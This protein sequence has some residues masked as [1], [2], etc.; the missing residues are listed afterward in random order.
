MDEDINHR[1]DCNHTLPPLPPDR[2]A[3]SINGPSESVFRQAYQEALEEESLERCVIQIVASTT[4]GN[5]EVGVL[6]SEQDPPPPIPQ[7]PACEICFERAEGRCQGG[8]DSCGI[9]LCGGCSDHHLALYPSHTPVEFNRTPV[10][11]AAYQEVQKMIEIV[12]ACPDPGCV[13][14]D[15]CCACMEEAAKQTG[16]S[17]S[18]IPRWTLRCDNCQQFMKEAQVRACVRCQLSPL[19]QEC[20]A[21]HQVKH[22]CKETQPAVVPGIPESEGGQMLI[23][24]LLDLLE[25]RDGNR[26]HSMAE[27]EL[28]AQQY[29]CSQRDFGE[30]PASGADQAEVI[31]EEPASGADRAEAAPEDAPKRHALRCKNCGEYMAMV[32]AYPCTR[33]WG[34][35]Y[36]LEC[37]EPHLDKCYCPQRSFEVCGMKFGP[38]IAPRNI[39]EVPLELVQDVLRQ[40]YHQ[41]EVRTRHFMKKPSIGSS[42]QLRSAIHKPEKD[43]L[44]A[45]AEASTSSCTDQQDCPKENEVLEELRKH[46]AQELFTANLNIVRACTTALKGNV[47]APILEC[48][49]CRSEVEDYQ[50]CKFLGCLAILCSKGCVNRHAE[51]CTKFQPPQPH[52]EETEAPDE[53]DFILEARASIEGSSHCLV[54]SVVKM[55]SMK[56]AATCSQCEREFEPTS[57]L[58]CAGCEDTDLRFCVDCSFIDRHPCLKVTVCEPSEAISSSWEKDDE[59]TFGRQ[60]RACRGFHTTGCVLD[61]ARKD[62]KFALRDDKN[63]KPCTVCSGYGHYALH[64]EVREQFIEGMRKQPVEKDDLAGFHN[65]I[66]QKTYERSIRRMKREKYC[67]LCCSTEHWFSECPIEKSPCGPA[68]VEQICF[69]TQRQK[70]EFSKTEQELRSRPMPEVSVP[71]Q[72]SQGAQPGVTSHRNMPSGSGLSVNK[73][74][75]WL[76]QKTAF[77]SAAKTAHSFPINAGFAAKFE[78]QQVTVTSIILTLFV[79]ALFSFF[80]YK[81]FTQPTAKSPK[82]DD[83]KPQGDD[84]GHPGDKGEPTGSDQYGWFTD[85]AV[86]LGGRLPRC[87]SCLK[88]VTTEIG[89]SL[90]TLCSGWICSDCLPEHEKKCNRAALVCSFMCIECC[91]MI[92][93]STDCAFDL[94]AH[95]VCGLCVLQAI[96]KRH[97]ATWSSVFVKDYPNK[98]SPLSYA[99]EK[100]SMARIFQMLKDPNWFTRNIAWMQGVGVEKW[101]HFSRSYNNWCITECPKSLALI[102]AATLDYQNI[103][104]SHTQITGKMFAHSARLWNDLLSC[105]TDMSLINAIDISGKLMRDESPALGKLLTIAE[106]YDYEFKNYD[107]LKSAAPKGQARETPAVDASTSFA[108]AS[109]AAAQP[110]QHMFK[111]LFQVAMVSI[112]KAFHTIAGFGIIAFVFLVLLIGLGDEKVS[113]PTLT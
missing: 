24:D 1:F 3:P 83:E 97:P 47:D 90:C 19:H 35:P 61:I 12:K 31:P 34:T 8:I 18:V 56:P 6:E 79:L 29:Y 103:L 37:L 108:S 17:S 88:R 71:D 50:S 75:S 32:D 112:D 111:S 21:E 27:V 85:L 98:K 106:Q 15:P 84:K 77:L 60:C 65:Q 78:L 52:Q 101:N 94:Q 23:D 102:Y 51:K 105:G 7:E 64:H 10:S 73:G 72:S 58:P 93:G 38:T 87:Q 39:Q 110:N 30:E 99:E 96:D 48:E 11:E 26:D 66:T 41:A 59:Q 40:V 13:L 49:V 14:L 68:E 57:L 54:D 107:N 20:I 67:P 69:F 70:E 44:K 92:C 2:P 46:Y 76:L 53:I 109:L 89:F 62:S 100:R 33:C 36:H 42:T 55:C 22:G 16:G 28:F 80:R 5:Q 91:Q 4:L 45:S 113:L 25:K 81:Y 104:L 9:F 63:E 86:S 43:A 82:K 74:N 95:H